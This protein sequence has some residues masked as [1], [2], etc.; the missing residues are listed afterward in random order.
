MEIEKRIPAND[1]RIYDYKM[2]TESEY[3]GE[4]NVPVEVTWKEAQIPRYNNA[5]QQDHFL[6]VLLRARWPTD[7]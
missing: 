4:G 3:L 1:Y 7:A 6:A 2:I 5:N